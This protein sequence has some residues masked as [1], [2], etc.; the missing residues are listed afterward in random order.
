MDKRTMQYK[1]SEKCREEIQAWLNTEE[2]DFDEGYELF[3]RY[4]H[5]RALALQL[6]RIRRQSKLVYELGK[7]VKQAFIKESR[8]FPVR[9]VIKAVNRH[10]EHVNAETQIEETG[11]RLVVIDERVKYEDLPEEMKK[12]YDENKES[13]K[14]MRVVHEKMKLATKDGERADFRTEL[15]RFDDLIAG[16]WETLDKWAAAKEEFEKQ[17]LIEIEGGGSF[18]SAQDDETDSTEEIVSE[19]KPEEGKPQVDS[20]DTTQ[21]TKDVNAARSYLSRNVKKVAGLEGKKQEDLLKK[22]TERVAILQQHNAEIKKS[23]REELVKLGLLNEDNGN[24]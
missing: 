8:V 23:T 24:D 12:L 16:N 15:V 22:L 20:I 13:Y 5:N 21:V 4:S 3:V 7:I 6:A 11:K 2:Q 1:E 10:Q 19:E 17:R 14:L 9:K 18:D